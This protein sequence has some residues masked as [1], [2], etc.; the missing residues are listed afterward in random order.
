VIDMARRGGSSRTVNR[1]AGT[2]RFVTATTAARHPNTT[3]TQRV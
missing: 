2:G 3:I 1:S